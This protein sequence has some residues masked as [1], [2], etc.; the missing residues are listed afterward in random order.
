MA[1]V[2][3]DLGAVT[4]YAYA[5]A[6]GYTGTEAEFTELLGNIAT[7]LSEIENLSVTVST[8]PAGSSATA[9][10]SNGVL[11]L[12]IPKGDKGD[13]GATPNI[14]IGTV[15]KLL[16]TQDATATITGTAESPVL[17]L[18]IPQGYSGD[19]N[20]LAPDYSSSNTYSVGDYCIHDGSL[21]RCKTAI[22]TAESWTAAHW[23]AVA[24]SDD[25]KQH[26]NN[27]G[28]DT[29]VYEVADDLGELLIRDNVLMR[30]Y[31]SQASQT[32]DTKLSQ[33]TLSKELLLL[34]QG[35]ANTGN[36]F[37][38][39]GRRE[40][41]SSSVGIT[42]TWKDQNTINVSGTASSLTFYNLITSRLKMIPGL[43]AGGEMRVNIKNNGTNAYIRIFVYKNGSTSGSVLADVYSDA[44]V[45]IP[46]DATGL[47]IRLDVKKDAAYASPGT[48]MEIGL[49]AYDS[50]KQL[51]VL[52]IG[53]S[54]TN[55]C[56]AY[57]PLVMENIA[58]VSVTM[59]TSYSSGASIDDYIDWFDNDTAA[60]SYYKY[61]GRSGKWDDGVSS[62]TIK[63][64]IA[65]E[66]WDII[67][68]QQK[69]MSAGTLSSFA[70]LNS[71]I[72]KVLTYNASVHSKPVRIGWLMPQLRLSVISTV[73]YEDVISCVE[74]ILSTTPVDFVIP[75]GTAVQTARGT[76]LNSI[77]TS[78]GLTAD[79][80]GHLQAG[81]PSLLA[82]YVV[83]LK[84]LDICGEAYH[85]I[86]WENTRP[87]STWITAHN[88]PQENGPSVGVSD[89][90]CYLAQKCAVAAIKKP[91]EVSLIGG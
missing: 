17:N 19:A 52:C 49:Y 4:A 10:Y 90:N 62:K 68:F 88:T 18:G 46:S 2:V 15:Q 35:T 57:A 74:N 45:S 53:N 6:G 28:I 14:T 13:T 26:T 66:D 55:D 33:T 91:L 67:T 76:S 61:V 64:I 12:G 65:D 8:L 54:Y 59:G 60:L 16:P 78:G 11:S 84:L 70:N 39:F 79:E 9:S 56:V 29:Y 43:K 85:G 37:N 5:V 23:T 7:D 3:K 87:N 73:T 41:Y 71:L 69:S 51:K 48:D 81:L 42:Y 21:Y 75:C 80:N 30:A 1:T 27:A 63:Q 82:S 40:T 83:A 20:N 50:D 32:Y 89:A 47:M 44:I 38:L 72:D 58:G 25:V 22:Q 31:N 36:L 77:G 24:L 86:L 34:K